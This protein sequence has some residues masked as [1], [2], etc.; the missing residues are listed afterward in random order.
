V[1]FS[2]VLQQQRVELAK[3]Y[4]EQEELS[5]DEVAYLLGYSEQSSFGRAFRRWT[6]STPQSYRAQTSRPVQSRDRR[7]V[8]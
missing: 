6:G 4:L 5:L 7:Q 8:M 1:R 2:N 3:G